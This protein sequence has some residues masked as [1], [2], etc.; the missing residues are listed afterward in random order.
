MGESL[1]GL[2]DV[3]AVRD[4]WSCRNRREKREEKGNVGGGGLS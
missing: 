2:D 1:G 4:N 3:I